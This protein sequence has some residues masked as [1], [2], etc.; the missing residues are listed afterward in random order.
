MGNYTPQICEYIRSNMKRNWRPAKKNTQK[1][2]RPPGVNGNK[3]K[4]LKIEMESQ[5]E[6]KRIQRKMKIKQF[7]I[8][9]NIHGFC[10]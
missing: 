1:V 2:L 6:K 4:R 3:N 9:L 5:A 7:S 10:S 8:A